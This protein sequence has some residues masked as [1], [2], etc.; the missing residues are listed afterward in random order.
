M[1]KA[2]VDCAPVGDFV[3]HHLMVDIPANEDTGE[4]GAQRQTAVGRKP[5]EGI[6]QRHSEGGTPVPHAQ[7]QRADAARDDGIE[8]DHTGCL[9]TTD[10]QLFAEER[11]AYFVNGDI[12]G[13]RRYGEQQ[14]EHD[15]HD[16]FHDRHGTECLLEDI[17]QRDEDERGTAVGLHTHREGCRKDDKSGEDGYQ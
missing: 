8:R 12:G 6:E 10:A 2:L 3:V 14:V 9:P 17:G 7:R 11:G 13:E 5:I 1:N 15:A 4:E 16:I